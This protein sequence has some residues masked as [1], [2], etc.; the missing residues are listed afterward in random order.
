LIWQI[1]FW[2]CHIILFANGGTRIKWAY[3]REVPFHFLVHGYAPPLHSGLVSPLL[4]DG[5]L[6]FIIAIQQSLSSFPTFPHCAKD[7]SRPTIEP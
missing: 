7:G 5:F 1:E 6:D 2:R 3:I 4:Y